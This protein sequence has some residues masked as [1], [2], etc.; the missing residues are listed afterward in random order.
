MDVFQP[1]HFAFLTGVVQIG[2][3]AF[4]DGL[5]PFGFGDDAVGVARHDFGNHLHPLGWVQPIFAELVEALGGSGDF[6]GVGIG[7]LLRFEVGGEAFGEG[8]SIEAS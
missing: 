3:S 6:G 4:L 2:E 1:L 7:V 5:S 8:K